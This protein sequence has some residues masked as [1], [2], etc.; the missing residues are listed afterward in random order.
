MITKNCSIRSPNDVRVGRS[1][2]TNRH[3]RGYGLGPYLLSVSRGLADQ[4][5]APPYPV[6]DGTFTAAYPAPQRRHCRPMR[7]RVVA[8]ALH[9]FV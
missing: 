5:G 3:G 2:A 7:L 4:S 8:A 6:G 9:A 1:R